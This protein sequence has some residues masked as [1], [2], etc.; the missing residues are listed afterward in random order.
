MD[1]E[2]KEFLSEGMKR[3]KEASLLMVRFGQN[4]KSEL[5]NILKNRT[6][7]GIFI[8]EEQ[9]KTK[10]T[11]YWDEYPLF[12]AEISGTINNAAHTIRISVNWFESDNNYP[13][14][15]IHFQYNNP[16]EEIINKF[17]AYEIQSNFELTRANNGLVMFPN[18]DDFNLSRDFNLLIDEFVKVI[19][20]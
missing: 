8:P 12:N 4:I 10:S 20:K 6:D 7:W 9:K 11:K 13:F 16:P 5:H 2:I 17:N 14:Y 15:S 3:Y 1:N 19:S 18:P